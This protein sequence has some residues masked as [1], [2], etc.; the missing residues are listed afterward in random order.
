MSA[1][2]EALKV[3]IYP[4]G[5]AFTRNPIFLS[6]SS[7]SMAT[8]SIRM[9]NEEIF[10]GNG[11]GEFRVNIAEIVET[12]IASTPI[13]PDNTEPLLAVSGLS[14]KVTIHVVNEG[15]NQS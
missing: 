15:G 3:N 1:S 2:D 12:G 5:N 10:K 7:Y 9:N 13:L 14:A 4:T 6:V 8:Y 11:I